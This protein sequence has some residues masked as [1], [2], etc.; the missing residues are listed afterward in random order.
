MAFPFLRPAAMDARIALGK[1]W[2]MAQSPHSTWVLQSVL[3]DAAGG[4]AVR[5]KLAHELKGHV[6]SLIHI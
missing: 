1:V 4:D 3:Q 5:I 6:L 2:H